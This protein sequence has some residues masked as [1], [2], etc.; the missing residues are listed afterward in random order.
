[1]FDFINTLLFI[2][3]DNNSY[4]VGHVNVYNLCLNTT[5]N[6]EDCKLTAQQIE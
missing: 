6:S 1:M 3:V 2:S 5:H 4:V